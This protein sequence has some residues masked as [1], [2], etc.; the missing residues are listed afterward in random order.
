VAGR[1]PVGWPRDLPP[2]GTDEFDAKVTGWLLDRG[3]ADLRSSA[4]RT[5]PIALARYLARIIDGELEATR[6]AY[7]TARVDLGRALSPDQLT[8]VQ[9]ALEA[10]GARLLQVQREVALVEQAL[11]RTGDVRP[12]D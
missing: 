8:Q 11:A 7:A 3:P 6:N 1:G 2:P 5:W 10:E 12:L 4:L 9:A